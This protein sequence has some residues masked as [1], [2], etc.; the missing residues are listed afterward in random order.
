MK[1]EG[2]SYGSILD[3]MRSTEGHIMI[4]LGLKEIPFTAPGWGASFLH[5]Q[6]PTARTCKNVLSLKTLRILAS[7]C[8]GTKL[9]S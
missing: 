9:F 5:Q 4:Y 6:Y 2:R 3:S 8:S 7:N 1:W